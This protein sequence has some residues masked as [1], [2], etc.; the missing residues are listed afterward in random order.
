MP[1]DLVAEKL[2]SII[3]PTTKSK[4]F[5]HK[6]YDPRGTLGSECQHCVQLLVNSLCVEQQSYAMYYFV[7]TGIKNSKVHQLITS[8]LAIMI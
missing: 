5:R 6:N 1:C 4:I 3:Q 2:N 8:G 7:P